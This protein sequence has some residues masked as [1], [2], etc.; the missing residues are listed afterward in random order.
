[1]V[2]ASAPTEHGDG[3]IWRSI[4]AWIGRGHRIEC[5]GPQASRPVLVEA[6]RRAHDGRLSRAI[7]NCRSRMP[8]WAVADHDT[9]R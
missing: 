7:M 4:A 1:M 2:L 3:P 9:R 6:G 8:S 5:S